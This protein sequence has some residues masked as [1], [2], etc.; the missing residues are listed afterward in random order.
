M[1]KLTKYLIALLFLGTITSCSKDD[2]TLVISPC[3]YV[4]CLNGG[5]CV[6][7]DCFCPSGYKGFNCSEIIKPSK[8][9]INRIELT[10]YDVTKENGG[11][12]DD[13][14]LGSGSGPDVYIKIFKGVSDSQNDLIFTS[15]NSINSTG[16]KIVYTSGLPFDIDFVETYHTI[17]YMD[18]DDLDSSDIFSSDDF[19]KSGVITS[20]WDGKSFPTTKNF[21]FDDKYNLKFFIEYFW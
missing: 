11:S 13:S 20:P 6:D 15:E 9:R 16:S 2:E 17:I 19:M 7:G 21:K 3:E 10:N 14:V 5:E 4:N 8:M 12:W 18:K 1:K